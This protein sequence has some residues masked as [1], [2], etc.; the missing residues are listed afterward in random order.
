[1]FLLVTFRFEDEHLLDQNDF[2]GCLFGKLLLSIQGDHDQHI[3]FEME[4]AADSSYSLFSMLSLLEYSYGTLIYDEMGTIMNYHVH[5]KDDLLTIELVVTFPADDIPP[6][7]GVFAFSRFKPAVTRHL[8][9]AQSANHGAPY[10]PSDDSLQ[11]LHGMVRI[12]F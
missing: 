12:L 6:Q 3:A 10:L 2:V 11:H 4:D 8:S 9:Q 1:M 5:L 7:H